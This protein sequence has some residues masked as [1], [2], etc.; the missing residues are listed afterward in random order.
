MVSMG[1][2]AD[3]TSNVG[4]TSWR[5]FVKDGEDL[6]LVHHPTLGFASSAQMARPLQTCWR[7]HLQSHSL[8]TTIVN[9]SVLTSLQKMKKD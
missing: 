7:T 5:R 8:L 4:G 6:Y 1:D 3:G 2:V 9:L